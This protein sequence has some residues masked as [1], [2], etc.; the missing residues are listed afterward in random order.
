RE[1]ILLACEKDQTHFAQSHRV[2][3]LE[4]ERRVELGA[5]GGEIA[6]VT[7]EP[8]EENVGRCGVGVSFHR[9]GE[10]AARALELTVSHR[11]DAGGHF[12]A[13]AGAAI[14]KQNRADNHYD[15]GGDDDPYR[16]RQRWPASFFSGGEGVLHLTPSDATATG[17]GFGAGG[18]FRHEGAWQLDGRWPGHL[19]TSVRG[20]LS[21][22]A[23]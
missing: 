20:R 16:C 11:V 2:S 7:R 5:R 21:V 6:L 22:S 3:R 23:P 1:I 12:I 19:P 15:D 18:T 9:F 13:T 10:F 17:R 14:E 4:P 8:G